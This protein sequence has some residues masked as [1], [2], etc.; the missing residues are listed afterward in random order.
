[1]S[2]SDNGDEGEESVLKELLIIRA[3]EDDIS[4]LGRGLGRRETRSP[5]LSLFSSSDLE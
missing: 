1:M 5:S 2:G 4:R 3:S